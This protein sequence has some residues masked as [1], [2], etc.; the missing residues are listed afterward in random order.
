M[1]NPIKH[2]TA[3]YKACKPSKKIQPKPYT[4]GYFMKPSPL[5]KNNTLSQGKNMVMKLLAKIKQ[6]F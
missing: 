1:I 6:F 2:C 3:I 4:E 5:A